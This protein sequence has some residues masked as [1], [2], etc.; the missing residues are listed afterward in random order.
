MRMV[1]PIAVG[2]LI[3]GTLDIIYAITAHG[4][5]GVPAIK[6]WQSVASGVQ[7]AEAYSGGM[8]SAIL[9]GGLHYFIILI[10]ASVYVGAS[11]IFPILT[12][13]P[14]ASGLAYGVVLMGVMNYI[15]VPLSAAVPG[16]VP[17]GWFFVGAIF[18]HT[19]LVGLPIAL[20]AAKLSD[21]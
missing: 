7:G 20:A 15:V 19:C 21:R 11:Q 3:A 12:S 14:V 10:M 17:E 9:G 16:K 2:W 13:R 4:L 5:R 1:L 8:A 18:A 6:I